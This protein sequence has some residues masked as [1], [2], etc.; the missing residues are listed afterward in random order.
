MSGPL[1][2][3]GAVI[4]ACAVAL[5]TAQAC[6]RA[7]AGGGWSA[8]AG[9]ALAVLAGT[10]VGGWLAGGLPSLPPRVA[11]GRLLA[12]GLPLAAVAEALA[13]VFAGTPSGLHAKARAGRVAVAG[14]LRWLV[15]A[16]RCLAALLLVRVLLHDSV[17]LRIG[18][19][20]GREE[21]FAAAVLAAIAWPFVAA[22]E[23]RADGG[24]VAVLA[25]V[26]SL[27]AAAMAIPMAGY[28]KGGLVAAL[29]AASVAGSLAGGGR[30]GLAGFGFAAVVGIVAV[31][32]FFGGLSAVAAFLLCIPPVLAVAAGRVGDSLGDV[33]AGTV[34]RSAAYRL[35]VAIVP[36]VVVLTQSWGEFDRSFRR[37]IA[38]PPRIDGSPP[39]SILREDRR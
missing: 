12:V 25:A 5:A 21:L 16:V 7:G 4:A 34:M 22:G 14:G 35:A 10:A 33:V 23:R 2:F 36:L 13:A 15:P 11:V 9:A 1:T 26:L 39:P 32:R 30:A 17:H 18:G 24:V 8:A 31:G 6:R 37:M 3:G 27:A 38:P 20:A 19:T 29:L 28:V